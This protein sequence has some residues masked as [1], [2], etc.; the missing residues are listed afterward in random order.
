MVAKIES[1]KSI[2]G[3]L[4]YNEDKVSLGEAKL[5]MASGFAGEI[6][7]MGFGQKINR[8]KRLTS[9]NLRVK[10]NTVHISLNFD[11]SDKLDNAKLQQIAASYME[12]IGFADQ[13][14]LVYRHL[15]AHHPHL[16]IL[17][18]NV[19]RSGVPINIHGIG[20][21]LSEPARKELEV[22]FGLVKAEGRE[23]SMGEKIRSAVYGEKPTKKL[24]SNTV[25][26]VMRQYCYGSFAEYSA[27]LSRFN[28]YADRGGQDTQMFQKGGLQYSILDEYGKPVGVPIKAS[29]IYC[30][31]TLKELEKRFEKNKHK[32][33]GYKEAVKK[34][35]D[36]C[37]AQGSATSRDLFSWQLSKIGIDVVFRRSEDGQVYGVTYIDHR[38]KTV[39]NGSDLGKAYSAKALEE[40][41]GKSESVV[42]KR[43]VGQESQVVKQRSA[44][45]PEH[46]QQHIPKAPAPISFLE[47]ALAQTQDETGIKIP[48]RRKKRRKGKQI[49]Q[50]Q[51]LTM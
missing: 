13:P 27:V 25:A 23:N 20:Y 5:L 3:A 26:G 4:L 19:T 6:D 22:S 8:F 7:R 45:A 18:T 44:M 11:A 46:F 36:Q 34:V 49:S 12:K 28:I 2:R 32:K 41:F 1:G 37:L 21:R 17:T 16:H 40:R 51:Q 42:Q 35:L 50:D 15:D 47:I 9:L 29:S 31:P 48:K 33:L 30:R 10:T 39:F 24:I 14:F 38:T 43:T